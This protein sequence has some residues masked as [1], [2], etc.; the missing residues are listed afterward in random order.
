[1]AP[2]R[3]EW[4][5]ITSPEPPTL[6]SFRR[7]D[8][9]HLLNLRLLENEILANDYIVFQAGLSLGGEVCSDDLLALVHIKRTLAPQHYRLWTKS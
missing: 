8:T 1:M 9:T 5:T 4:P 7:F 6:F 2:S 3:K